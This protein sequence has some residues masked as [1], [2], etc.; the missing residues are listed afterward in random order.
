M[1]G[2][3]VSAMSC[4][5]NRGAESL[6]PAS[7]DSDFDHQVLIGFNRIL[8]KGGVI[9]TS[10]ATVQRRTLAG[11]LG[12]VAQFSSE[13]FG[14]KRSPGEGVI[15]QQVVVDA[16]SPDAFNFTKVNAAEKI[17]E[18]EALPEEHPAGPLRTTVLANV[19]PLATGH[20]LLVP[21]CEQVRPQVL[22]EELMLC[23]LH[24]LA[25]SGRKDFRLVFNS[26][27]GFATVNHFHFHGLYLSYCGLPSAQLPVERVD[28]SIIA[29]K[30]TEG[31]TQIELIVDKCWYC[32]GFV[33]SAGCKPGTPGEAP[34]ADIAALAAMVARVV[35][36]LQRRNIPHN[37]IIAPPPTERRQKKVFTGGMA[38]EEPVKPNAI[39]PEVFIL[40]RKPE[41]ELRTDAGFNA[42]V[43]EI[44]GV[45]VAQSEEAYVAFEEGKLQ[46][47]FKS[48]V[49]LPDADFDELICKVAWLPT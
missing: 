4:C 3:R 25:K 28:R 22:T 23:G 33:V 12:L 26:L 11:A 6:L 21:Q 48:D 15:A 1:S 16:V 8:D 24:L 39:S 9:R 13:H 10:P 34:P 49:S 41:S 45:L 40:P 32:S 43:M 31:C 44:S 17:C 20:V 47:I 42:A 2:I 5:W 30:T 29:G 14:K 7:R 38:H 37:V 27:L 46:E 35:Q 19:S 36:E 18:V